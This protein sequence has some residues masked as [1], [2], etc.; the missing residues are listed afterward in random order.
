MA[1]NS[2]PKVFK[3]KR[4]QIGMNVLV[5]L[6]TLLVILIMV[7]YLAFAHYRRWDFSRN[8]KY[9]VS[10]TTKRLLKSLKKP[11]KV[12][13]FFTVASDIRGDIDTLLKEYQY[14]SRKKM[15]V[16]TVDPFR[17]LTRARELV[18]K[19][20]LGS[21]ENLVILDY[22]GRSKFVNATDMADYDTSNAMYGKAPQLIDFKGEQA[23]TGALLELTEE[24]QQKI[25]FLSGHGEPDLA[26]NTFATFRTFLE[27]QN[28][29]LAKLGLMDV[30][31][32]PDDAKAIFILDAKY[33]LTDRETKLLRDYWNKNGRLFIA[34]NPNSQTPRL[35]TFLNDQG[36]K[37]DDN[38]VL[39]TVA[40]GPVT[41][42]LRDVTG[43][44]VDGSAITKRLKGVNTQF[45]GGTQSLTLDQAAAKPA[46]IHLQGLIEAAEGY[47]GEAEYN[48]GENAPVFFDPQKDKAPPLII[49]ASVE[50]GAIN[51]ARVQVDSSR[52]VVVGSSQ[53]VMNEALTEANVDFAL[54]GL[55]WLLDREELVG[56]APKPSNAFSLNL[57]EP[58]MSALAWFTVGGFAAGF[59]PTPGIIPTCA[60]FFGCLMWL[61]R[62]N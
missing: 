46:N 6:F 16:E 37:P 22:D 41:G 62:R 45:L 5:Q 23:I 52:M 48:A 60:A 24:K 58:Q 42:I 15:D 53:F 51:D 2:A 26:S 40:L 9:A 39:R 1:E 38:R 17:N 7:N 47:W 32:V 14:A 44:F 50:K 33:D 18:A 12:I 11:V 61:K 30:G 29:Q 34:I 3:I 31:Q 8:Q 49:A 56:I 54:S 25:Y 21:N 55:N 28:L 57:T 19:Y 4:F 43:V 27:R 13:V 10:D 20:K 35:T 36:V 59:I